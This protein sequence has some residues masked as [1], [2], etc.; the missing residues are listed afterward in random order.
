M[1]AE[2]DDR[3]IVNLD[4]VVKI[5]FEETE[6]GIPAYIFKG[7]GGVELGRLLMGDSK[8]VAKKELLIADILA[9]G[10]ET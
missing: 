3:V 7:E 1:F 4:K 8:R 9:H 5:V 2:L 10:W 6:N